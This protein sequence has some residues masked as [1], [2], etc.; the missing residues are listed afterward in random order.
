MGNS[1]LFEENF[2]IGFLPLRS[3]FD[4]NKQIGPGKQ[5]PAEKQNLVRCLLLRDALEQLNCTVRE[6]IPKEEKNGSGSS[7]ESDEMNELL[8]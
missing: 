4:Q 2:L 8:A 5:C 7:M 1:L 6:L 3:Y